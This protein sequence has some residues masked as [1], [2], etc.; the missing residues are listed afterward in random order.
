M[1]QIIYLTLY[2]ITHIVSEIK[3]YTM[4]KGKKIAL[5]NLMSFFKKAPIEKTNIYKIYVDLAKKYCDELQDSDVR[6][7]LQQ[8]EKLSC[9]DQNVWDLIQKETSVIPDRITFI[10]DFSLFAD[11]VQDILK[12]VDISEFETTCTYKGAQSPAIPPDEAYIWRS[13]A[14]ELPLNYRN[15]EPL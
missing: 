12:G 13:T 4:Q 10:Y 3:K 2:L 1:C 15:K 11:I 6:T 5:Q 14:D 9:F 8:E 7:F